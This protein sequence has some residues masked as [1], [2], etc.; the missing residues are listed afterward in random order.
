MKLIPLTLGLFAQVDDHWFK[1]LNQYKWQAHKNGSTYYATRALKREGN[2][3]KVIW[4]HRQIMNTL[5]GMDCDHINH[6]GLNNLE[7]NLRNCNKNQNAWNHLPHGKSPY[8][9]VSYAGKYIQACISSYGKKIYLGSFKT[10]EEA[11]R[12]YDKKAKELFGEFANLNF[13]L[14]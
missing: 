11:A 7:E 4:M 9:G 2:K 14:L 1:E 10:E 12:A 6:N 13:K 3:R 8:L 5:E